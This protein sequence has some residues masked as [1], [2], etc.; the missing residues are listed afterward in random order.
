MPNQINIELL[1]GKKVTGPNNRKIGRIEEITAEL[2][3]GEAYVTEFHIGSYAVL[4][5]FA[6][7]AMG[8]PILNLFGSCRSKTTPR[9]CHRCQLDL[10]TLSGISSP[11]LWRAEANQDQ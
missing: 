10:K 9:T 3:K 11:M 2:R 4:E 8:R 7:L 1:L 6:A 5:R